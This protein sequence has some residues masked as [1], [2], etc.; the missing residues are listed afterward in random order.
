MSLW[1]IRSSWWCSGL[2]AI[3]CSA[4]AYKPDSH[5]EK[6]NLFLN[7]ATHLKT[8]EPSHWGCKDHHCFCDPHWRE[9]ERLRS[10]AYLAS[11]AVL[12]IGR[13]QKDCS[14]QLW[15]QGWYLDT[16][17]S[18][19]FLFPRGDPLVHFAETCRASKITKK[20]GSPHK[21]IV[22]NPMCYGDLKAHKPHLRRPLRSMRRR[23]SMW[24]K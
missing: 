10:F 23:M 11:Y 1:L 17:F 9:T 18:W 5:L 12:P 16:D 15:K 7:L 21:K 24:T 2:S 19:S 6:M 4:E 3:H 8:L 20:S 14:L 22:K 13:D